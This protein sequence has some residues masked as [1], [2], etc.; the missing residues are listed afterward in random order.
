MTTPI[1]KPIAL[2]RGNVLHIRDG[3]GSPVSRIA[4]VDLKVV[5]KR[6][7]RAAERYRETGQENSKGWKQA[8]WP[9]AT[10]E[11]AVNRWLGAN[12]YHALRATGAFG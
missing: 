11:L 5:S 9:K 7:R 2:A 1:V 4:S 8:T 12:A 3:R 10:N 6:V